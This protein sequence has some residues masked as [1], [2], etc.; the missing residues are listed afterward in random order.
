[1]IMLNICTDTDHVLGDR[2]A[3][4]QNEGL[5]HNMEVKTLLQGGRHTRHT[6]PG[7]TDAKEA[8]S[9]ICCKPNLI[10]TDQPSSKIPIG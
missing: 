10:I 5:R 4:I 3:Y 8:N 2:E 9:K 6:L 1:M 7:R